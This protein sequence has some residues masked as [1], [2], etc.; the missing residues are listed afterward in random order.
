MFFILYVCGL[1]NFINNYCCAASSAL[2]HRTSLVILIGPEF[3]DLVIDTSG[4]SPVIT[5]FGGVIFVVCIR[6]SGKLTF[7]NLVVKGILGILTG[8]CIV[9]KSSRACLKT[10]IF[11]ENLA[12]PNSLYLRM[13]KWKLASLPS[14]GFLS[15]FD[16]C[17]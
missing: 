5:P 17:L 6:P 12:Y 16:S 3:I 8:I 11:I 4:L 10:V 9:I 15:K 14:P 7:L 13:I 1:R 2:P